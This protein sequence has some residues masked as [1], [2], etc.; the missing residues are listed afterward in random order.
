MSDSDNTSKPASLASL[1]PKELLEQLADTQ[2]PSKELLE[3]LAHMQS[4]IQVVQSMLADIGDIHVKTYE[5]LWRQFSQDFAQEMQR[6]RNALDRIELL[7]KAGW[8]LPMSM[9]LP[10]F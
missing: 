8:T 7:A 10:E 4:P 9:S 6:S 1:L 5:D 3:H 2:V